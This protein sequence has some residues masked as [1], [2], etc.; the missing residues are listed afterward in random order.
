MNEKHH[1]LQV[2]IGAIL[3][4]VNYIVK[5]VIQLLYVPIMLRYLD[6]NEYGV[7]QLVASLISYLSLLNF[8]FGGAY[9]RFYAQCKNDCKKQEKVNGTF[10]LVFSFFSLLAL[11]VGMLITLSLIHI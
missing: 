2:K 4:Y 8:G 9:L 1:N 3:G 10:L 11:I 5:M 6:Q 7:Y